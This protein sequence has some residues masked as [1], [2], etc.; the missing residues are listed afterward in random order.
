MCRNSADFESSMMVAASRNKQQLRPLQL[1]PLYIL[2]SVSSHQSISSHHTGLSLNT[3]VPGTTGM[4]HLHVNEVAEAAVPVTP[5]EVGGSAE[6]ISPSDKP[7]M[8][9]QPSSKSV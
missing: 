8:A 9:V 4:L 3:I 5:S 2:W 1:L 6:N 7:D